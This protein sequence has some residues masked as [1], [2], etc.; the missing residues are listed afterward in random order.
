MPLDWDKLRVFNAVA[1]AGSFTHA[2]D[3]LGLSQ[4]AV[5]RQISALEHQL[6][7]P[8]F[9]RHA[10]GLVLT[11]QGEL[12]FRTSR[13]V[14]H[15]L[16]TVRSKLTDS[17]ERP[18]GDL[19]ITTTIG[20]G[21]DWLTPRLVNFIELYPDVHVRLMLDDNE[22]DLGKREADVAI[23]LRQPA[24]PDLVQRRLFTV[25][26][27]VF[28]SQEYLDNFGTPKTV[29]DLDYHRILIFGE[30]APTYLRDMNRLVTV[31]RRGHSP[32]E[33]ALRINNVYGLKRAAQSGLGI[34]LLP[35]YIIHP[36]TS[37][38]KLE[39][40]DAPLPRFETF[41]AYP[42]ELRKSA[43]VQVFRDYLVKCAREWV[44]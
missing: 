24:Q 35:D 19:R 36:G 14:L 1:E 23:R 38:V 4:S 15:R 9:H 8:L 6:N 44:F 26:F 34:A 11:E 28:A 31:G 21:S 20:L 29:D 12:L 7:V 5:S 33:A 10:R 39:I 30:P 17:K 27:H 32:R 22:L 2:G 40:D 43:R 41:F 42:E 18:T 16:E 3:A 37:L 13:D 25:H